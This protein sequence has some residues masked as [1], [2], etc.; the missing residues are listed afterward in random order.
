MLKILIKDLKLF[1]YHGVR[2]E[3]KQDGQEFLFNIKILLNKDG[4]TGEDN[5]ERTLNYSEVIKLVK[6][7]NDG[8]RFDL[9]E[10]LSRTVAEEILKLSP[11][12]EKVKVRVEKISPPTKEDLYSV[13]VICKLQ[14]DGDNITAEGNPAGMA[15][16]DLY[17]SLGSNMGDR[18][19]NLQKGIALINKNP[20]I[21][22]LEVSSLYESEP[23]Y[24]EDQQS[25]YNI[26]VHAR[27]GRV[28]DP[29]EIL[30]FLKGIE[31]KTGRRKDS[32]KNGPRILDIDILYYGDHKINTDFLT[33]P[34]P[35]IRERNFVLLPL[36]EIAP[37]L[38]IDSMGIREYLIEKNFP[39]GV[40]LIKDS[41][42]NI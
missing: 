4:L 5:I 18:K 40:K 11:L 36:S 14:R 19:K 42:I 15:S 13:G 31:Y 10:T 2:D 29:F 7:I 34:H 17:L 16:T 1:G 27:A 28:L 33:V 25:F 26:V 20:H 32:K 12:A 39:E 9:L 35:G 41:K 23:M 8:R 24:L 37:G 21:D 3:E 38:K 6:K 30:G 22:I